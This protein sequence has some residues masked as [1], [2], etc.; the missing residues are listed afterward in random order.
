MNAAVQYRNLPIKHKLRLIIVLT[1]GAALLL[2]CGAILA[3]DYVSFRGAIRSDLGVLADMFGSN[4]TAALSFGDSH[5]A[6]ELLAGLKAK[7]SVAAACLYSADG[8]VF[9]EYRR[10]SEARMSAPLGLRAEGSWFQ[11]G[12][13]KLFRRVYLGNQ[14]VGAI[15]LESDLE[16]AYTRE[17]R[18]AGIVLLILLVAF[19][20]AFVLAQWLQR[21][22]SEPVAHLAETAKL[23]SVRK[24]YATRA[25]KLADDD[26]GQ[27]TDTFN[28]MLA[29]I[30]R[31]DEEL[32][33][34]GDRLEQEVTARTA[35]LR[36]ANTSLLDAKDRAEAAS[37]AKSEFLANMSHEIRT[38]MN[39][40]MGMTELVLD[41]PLTAEQRDYL[42][43]VKTSA[44]SLLTVINDILDF[45]KIEA[46]RMELDP[47]RFNLRDTLEEAVRALALRAHEKALELMCEFAPDV[48]DSVFGDP[49]R[50]RQVVV[51][52]LG[53]AVKFTPRGEVELQ[54]R[55]ETLSDDQMTLHFVVRDTGIGIPPEKQKLIFEA[56]SQADGSMTRRYGGTGLGLTISARLVE[57]M[58]GKIWVESQPGQGSCFHFTACFGVVAQGVPYPAP[59][60]VL[61]GLDVLVVDDNSTNRKI[62]AGILSRWGM[63]VETAASAQEALALMARARS[64]EHPFLLVVTDVHMPEM[65]GFELARRIRSSPHLGSAVILMLTSGERQGDIER[66]Q[67]LGVSTYLIKPVRRAELRAAIVQVL[68]GGWQH[69]KNNLVPPTIDPPAEIEIHTHARILVAEDNPVNQRLVLRVLEKAGH[70]VVI[71]GNGIEALSAL[72]R[73]TFDVVLMDVQ[74]PQMD[75][76]ETTAAIRSEEKKTKAH[77]PIIAM[78]AHAMKGDKERCLA[79]GMDGYISKPVRAAE[80]LETVEKYGRAE[81]ALA[82]PEA[83]LEA[84]PAT[85]VPTLR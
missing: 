36:T 14:V 8:R 55:V 71:A 37:R 30:E 70:D 11:S 81:E 38:P 58:H 65:D 73:Q 21:S 52:L 57:A 24:D 66:C 32:L 54:V 56:F 74:M 13:L 19:S 12:R 61:A 18:F 50:V 4:S 83:L 22:I 2:A 15:Y 63:R 34:H 77:I 49:V 9:A 85:T 33:R 79:A 29:E 64:V 62:L 5:V 72:H 3:Y 46:G 27:L 26:L 59:E 42:S 16:E 31:R 41:T 84:E 68:T 25:V 35:E 1:V 82:Q 40:I 39:G 28:G 60:P 44:D 75:G 6:E 67:E 43:T 80:V 47:I 10:K 53:N 17:K 69:V 78:T 48:P 23:V 51:N 7:Q 20:L 76:L 45:S